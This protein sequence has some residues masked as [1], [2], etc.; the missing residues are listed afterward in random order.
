MYKIKQWEIIF[1]FTP[2]LRHGMDRHIYDRKNSMVK[3]ENRLLDI[4]DSSFIG[5]IFLDAF[6]KKHEELVLDIKQI[7]E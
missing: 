7:T 1:V 5:Q 3:F 4:L 6:L 2:N